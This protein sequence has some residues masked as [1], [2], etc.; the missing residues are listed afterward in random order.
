MATPTKTTPPKS[1][2]D[3]ADASQ[4]TAALLKDREPAFRLVQMEKKPAVEGRI[5]VL[6]PDPQHI[7]EMMDER[8]PSDAADGLANCYGWNDDEAKKAAILDAFA[9]FAGITE[10]EVG[11]NEHGGTV[12]VYKPRADL[13]EAVEAFYAHHADHAEVV[14]QLEAATGAIRQVDEERDLPKWLY[15]AADEHGGLGYALKARARELREMARRNYLEYTEG[16]DR[17]GVAEHKRRLL[18]WSDFLADYR[19]KH[20]AKEA[21]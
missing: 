3:K 13:R 5:Q 12:S 16:F 19:A 14:K 2:K 6:P 18:G 8:M 10:V 20:P 1:A 11:K 9:A 21:A 17:E 7:W 15:R 4:K